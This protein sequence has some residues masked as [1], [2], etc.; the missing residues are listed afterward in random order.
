M[1]N[2]KEIDE[3]RRILGLDKEASMEEIKGAFRDLA[4]KFHPDRCE[5]KDKKCCEEM[6]KK[7][8]HA[9]DIIVSYCANYRFSF[10]EKEVKKNTMSKAEYDHLKR[11]YDGWLGDL[12]L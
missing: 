10:A 11:F 5:D 12:D 9:K 1:S 8:N 7:V 4:L 6:F 3:A 2:F